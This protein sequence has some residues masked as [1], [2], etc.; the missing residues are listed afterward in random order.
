MFN[1]YF[2]LLLNYLIFIIFYVELPL[3]QVNGL[4][5]YLMKQKGKIMAQYKAKPTLLALMNMEYL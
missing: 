4:E 3:F 2:E 1:L 5:W